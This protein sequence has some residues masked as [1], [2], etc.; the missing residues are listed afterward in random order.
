M[1]FKSVEGE[2]AKRKEKTLIHLNR[3]G[4]RLDLVVKTVTSGGLM[5][6]GVYLITVRRELEAAVSNLDVATALSSAQWHHDDS[7]GN[8]NPEHSVCSAC[9][10]VGSHSC[11][12]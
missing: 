1:R 5:T 3:A 7:E 4:L 10:G 9:G 8:N 11:G 6:A 2:I 12:G